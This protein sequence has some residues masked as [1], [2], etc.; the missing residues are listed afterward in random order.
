MV[1]GP[2]E[3]REDLFQIEWYEV[4]WGFDVHVGGASRPPISILEPGARRFA[5]AG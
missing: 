5:S 3:A 2:V 1:Q 4:G